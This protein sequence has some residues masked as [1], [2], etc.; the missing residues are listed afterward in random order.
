MT[1]GAIGK[2]TENKN[3]VYPDKNTRRIM[4]EFKT[5]SRHKLNLQN[6]HTHTQNNVMT[7][8]MSLH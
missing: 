3:I 4:T 5:N 8:H 2:Y 7:L 1:M 6:K